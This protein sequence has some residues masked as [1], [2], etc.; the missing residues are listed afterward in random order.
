MTYIRRDL[1]P[2]LLKASEQYPIV[3][4]TGPR[5]VGKTTM[6]QRLMEE[7]NR[8]YVTLDDLTERSLAQSD[9]EMFFQ[10]HKP[11]ILIDE[12]QYAP[13]LFPY[14]KL[15]ADR[16]KIP[17]AFWMTGSQS[18]QLMKLTGESLAGRACILS[19]PSLS[20]NELYGTGAG[21][22]FTLNQEA[23]V[24]RLGNRKQADTPAMYERIFRGSMPALASGRVTGRDLFYS[25]YL[26]TYIGRDIRELDGAVE[27][28][29]F[30]RFLTAVACRAGQ[31]VNYAD[32]GGDVGGMR[33]EKVQAWLGLL[34][35]SNIIFYLHPYANNL[36]K[37]TVSK[38][39]LY[40]YDTG[41][42]AYLTRWS[43]PETL[44]SGA[45]SGAI[46]ENYVVS[47]MMKSYLNAGLQ[48]NL[49]YYRDNDAKEIDIVLECDGEVHP[50]EIKKTANP[51]PQLSRTFQVLDKGS[52]KRGMG[53]ILCMKNSLSATDGKCLVVPVWGI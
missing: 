17:G 15:I 40:F 50:M 35:Q 22:P 25:S 18:F 20:Q 41:L 32:I 33:S 12:V 37:R 1:E 42:V 26:Q 31:M 52:V 30:L 47:E 44:E 5:Q 16:E 10:L 53:A 48:P 49:Y 21:A 7:T 36:L 9:S 46:L 14:I 27:A 2:V 24:Q 3:L 29:D 8:A 43:S 19:L 39:K 51:A 28:V 23:L 4:V 13:Q 6:L 11:P 34:E 38:P 45:M